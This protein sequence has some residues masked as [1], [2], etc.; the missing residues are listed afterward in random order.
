MLDLE[1]VITEMQAAGYRLTTQRRAILNFLASTEVHHFKTDQGIDFLPQEEADRIAGK[2]AD[3]HR[4]DLFE[5]IRQGDY[6]N[7]TLKVQIMPFKEAET[8]R[9]NPFDLTKV[10]PHGDYPLHEVGRLAARLV[11]AKIAPIS[12]SKAK[13]AG[14]QAHQ[15]SHPPG[16]PVT[17]W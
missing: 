17:G 12:P 11:A 10:W 5:A 14:F 3:Y 1:N 8:Y 6:P 9:F 16:F 13:R 15:D 4:R 2:D 7:W